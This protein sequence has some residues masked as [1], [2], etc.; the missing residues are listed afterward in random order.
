M[1]AQV[2]RLN[3]GIWATLEGKV[4]TWMTQCDTMYVVTGAMPTTET[5]KSIT[6]TKDNEGQDVAVPKYYF[7]ALAMKKGTAYYTI[8][9]KMDNVIPPT[10]ASYTSYQLTVKDLEQMTGFTFFP[11]LTDT[12]K[13]NIDA[14]IWK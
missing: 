1:T 2:S 14:S 7:K 11:D 6:Y 13:G 12:Q 4:R 5:D 9:Y 10:G 3:Q 8:A